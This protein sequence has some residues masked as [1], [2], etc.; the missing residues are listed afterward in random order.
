MFYSNYL[1]T[2]IGGLS[3]TSNTIMFNCVTLESAGDPW[4]VALTVILYVSQ[5]SRSNFLAN[6]TIPLSGDIIK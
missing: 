3:L 5:V 4:S 6:V 2:N 1:W